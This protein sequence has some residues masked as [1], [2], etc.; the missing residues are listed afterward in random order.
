MVVMLFLG[1]RDYCTDAW[2]IIVLKYTY[3]LSIFLNVY[4]ISHNKKVLK[5]K[6]QPFHKS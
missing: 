4:F 6:K 5:P 1:L 3:D 2:I